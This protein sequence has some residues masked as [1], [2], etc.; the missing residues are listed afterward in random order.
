M[1]EVRPIRTEE[2][3]CFLELLC[4]VFELDVAR[5]RSVFYSEPYVDLGRKWALFVDD[6]MVLRLGNPALFF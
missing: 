6:A 5:A 2:A 4:S 3:E 1:T